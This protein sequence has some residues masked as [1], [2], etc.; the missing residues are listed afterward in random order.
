M[1]LRRL[2]GELMREHG[3]PGAQLALYREGEFAAVAAGE[4]V[5]GTGEEVTGHTAFPIGSVTKPFTAAVAMLLVE[6][7]DVEP[8]APFAEYLPELGSARPGLHRDMTLR[9]VLSHTAGL[10]ADPVS[11]N[12]TRARWI[13]ENCRAADMP[14]PPGKYFSYS[15]TGYVLAGHVVESVLGMSWP[16][17][18]ESVLLRPLGI[19]P[20]FVSGPGASAARPRAGGHVTGPNGVRPVVQSLSAIEA[21]SGALALSATDLVTF[22]RSQWGDPALPSP[23]T[24]E[25]AGRMRRGQL[26]SETAGPYGM[27]DDWGLGWALYRDGDRIWGGHDGTGDGTSA[28]LRFRPDA[29]TAVALTANA[30]TGS[31]LWAD[32]LRELGIGDAV[33]GLGAGS[34]GPPVPAPPDLAGRYVNGTGEFRAD[35]G[36]DGELLLTIDGERRSVVHREGA[37]FTVP[38]VGGGRMSHRGRFLRDEQGRVSHLQLAGRLANRA[39]DRD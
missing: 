38:D 19:S 26:G 27:A 17:A 16:E 21:P 13:A 34:A 8:D 4:R 11:P 9:Q 20:V 30:A 23:L 10:V 39:D 33:T 3:V 31:A 5:H 29:A 35:V 14:A 37:T 18:V 22:A 1:D 25:S 7:G 2:L 6:D 15:N 36:A 32:L 24:P 12:V 28:H